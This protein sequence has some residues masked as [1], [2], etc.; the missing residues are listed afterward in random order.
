MR[1]VP[2]I[3]LLTC[4]FSLNMLVTACKPA[5]QLPAPEPQAAAQPLPLA[6]TDCVLKVGFDAWEPYHYLGQGQ[7]AVGMDIEILQNLAT[8][9]QCELQLQQDAWTT[10]LA[11][12]Q[13]GE[14]DLLPG[15]SLSEERA[16]FA[17][18][19]EPY[20]QE[21]FVLYTRA[22][23]ELAF[24]DIPTLLAAG[25]KIGLVSDYYYGAE[26]DS[27]Y[28]SMPE[29]FLNAQIAE[30]NIVR[31]LDEDISAV[32][33]DNFV[34]TAM[35]RR[36]GLEQQIVA[37]S[38]SLPASDVHLMLSKASVSEAQLLELNNAIN[39]LKQNGSLAEILQRY[40]L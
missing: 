18:F 31:L 36:K 34:A 7:A 29:A 25:H 11:K 32:L 13:A 16:Q 10:L 21:Q 14:I 24:T 26:I 19:S 30:L 5:S 3:L 33:E 4:F 37:H 38:L 20:R 28:G 15:A 39:R 6:T 8:E 2:L 12:L 1:S 23:T 40:Q 27:L 9:M 22:D 17:W 35:L